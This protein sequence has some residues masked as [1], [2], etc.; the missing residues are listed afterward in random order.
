MLRIILK[1]AF[2]LAIVPVAYSYVP[3]KVSLGLLRKVG[4]NVHHNHRYDCSRDHQ[5]RLEAGKIDPISVR[6][7]M[8]QGRVGQLSSSNDNSPIRSEVKAQ[9]SSQLKQPSGSRS[10]PVQERLRRSVRVQPRRV[11]EQ[12]LAAEAG[13]VVY[14]DSNLTQALKVGGRVSP[15]EVRERMK[16]ARQLQNL[17]KEKKNLNEDNGLESEDGDLERLDMK[18]EQTVAEKQETTDEVKLMEDPLP[19][20][21]TNLNEDDG[22]ESEDDDLE[23]LEMK[24]EQTVAEKQETT[25]EVKLMEDPLPEENEDHSMELE[26]DNCGTLDMK[27]QSETNEDKLTDENEHMEN[28][29]VVIDFIPSNIIEQEPEPCISQDTY[30]DADEDMSEEERNFSILVNLGMVEVHDDPDSPDYDDSMDEE[31]CE[32]YNN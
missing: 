1:T 30:V 32:E 29:D 31:F 4:C 22:L 27:Q 23:R 5:M 7:R 6:E 8:R 19:E 3:S 20:E 28:N 10:I 26:E 16:R 24:R 18:R 2:L 15:I 21:N 14:Q 25:D 9:D 13:A 17:S 11:N 12:G